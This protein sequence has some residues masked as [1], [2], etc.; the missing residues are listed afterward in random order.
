MSRHTEIQYDYA[1]TCLSSSCHVST[2]MFRV[3]KAS[4]LCTRVSALPSVKPCTVVLW[5]R[6][7]LRHSWDHGGGG[8]GPGEG[9]ISHIVLGI[10]SS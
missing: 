9:G 7:V 10:P 3:T 5:T 1:L 4:D 6:C 2:V 8:G